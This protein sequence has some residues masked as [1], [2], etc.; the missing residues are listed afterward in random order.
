MTR[1]IRI[2]L[3]D[4]HPASDLCTTLETTLQSFANVRVSLRKDSWDGNT[5][6][7][8]LDVA[9]MTEGFNPDAFCIV[10]SPTH[11]ADFD[12]LTSFM[13]ESLSGQRVMVVIEQVKPEKLLELLKLGAVDVITA[14][15]RAV[16]LLGRLTRLLEAPLA[17]QSLA[18][19]MKEKLGLKRLVGESP[20][21][22]AE[23]QKIPVV[24]NSDAAVL[25]SGE[26]GTGK[27]LCARALHYLSSRSGKPF[28]AVNCGAMPV[29]LLEN[30]LFGHAQGA[31]T[32]AHTAQDGLIHEA[33]GGTLFLDEVGCLPFSS[34]VKLLRF[35]QDKEYKRLGSPKVYRA[36]VRI[37]AATNTDLEKA[38]KDGKFRLDF[39]YRLNVVPIVLP[40]IRERGEDIAI[41]AR[42]FLQKYAFEL[43]KDV[44]D[45][46]PESMR[47]LLLHT[48]PGNVRELEN[49]VERAIIFARQ[50]DIQCDE[51]VLSRSEPLPQQAS[52]FKK[53][54]AIA[55]E[56]F[57]K[58]YIHDLLV[59]NS[60]NI[61]RAARAARGIETG[62]VMG[63]PTSGR[64][65]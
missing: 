13:G 14:P 57:E 26:K 64:P 31:Y 36:D 41:L 33:D 12:A 52:S 34:Q 15:L 4:L 62:I 60:G 21:F 45:F 32:G 35:L 39:F 61:S 43:K 17:S 37:I 6:L 10:L 7:H 22:L 63:R 8:D 19:R 11:L 25:I 28:I 44:A 49:V 42:H 24:A 46:T 9:A 3:L 54:K 23:I 18:R 56:Q 59:A 2:F 29:D 27:D 38:V 53:A 55:I 5:A 47:I 58:R 16:D 20:A 50:K 48:W 51:I 1:S 40:P 65:V 30:E